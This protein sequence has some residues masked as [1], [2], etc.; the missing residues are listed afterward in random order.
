M[1]TKLKIK[2]GDLV[3]VTAGNHKGEQGTVLS[4]DLK[5]DRALVEGVNLV[6]RHTKPTPQQPE[7]KIVEKEAPL[8]L[9]NLMVVVKDTPSR[10]GRK[11]DESTGKLIRYS[12]KTG[13][14]IK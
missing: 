13:E 3:V 5:K 8:H 7:G 14:T 4:V 9:S 2:S 12:K 10:L 1:P 6:K 11:L